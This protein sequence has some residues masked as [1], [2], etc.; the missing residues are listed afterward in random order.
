MSISHKEQLMLTSINTDS[1]LKKDHPYRKI[2]KFLDLKPLVKEFEELYSKNGAPGLS[3]RKALKTMIIQFMEN[4]SDRQMETALNENIAVKWFCEFELEDD[5]PDHSFFG[6]FRKRLGTD[7]VAKIFNLVVRQMRSGGIMSDVFH[8]ID[9]TAIIS[10][11]ALWEERD[12]AINDGLKKP[13]NENV[14]KYGADNRARI[15]CKGKNKFWYG[16]KNHVAVEMKSGGITK[17]AVTPANVPDGK[18]LKN[19]CP[20]QGMIFAD[21]AYCGAETQREIKARGCHS[22]AILKANMKG[23]NR[24]LDPWRTAVRMPYE[25]VFAQMPKRARYRGWA[26]V[27]MQAFMQAVAHNLRCWLGWLRRD[28]ALAS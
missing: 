22:G 14:S 18:A 16:Y 17:V 26:K 25:G 21:K 12:R 4:L 8:F 5:T 28:P 19:V 2:N 15:G 7:N 1:L 23:K 24:Y 9:S 6:K 20:K 10:K 27:Q 3:I 11:T 13:D